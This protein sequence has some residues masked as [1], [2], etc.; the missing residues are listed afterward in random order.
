MSQGQEQLSACCCCPTFDCLSGDQ[1]GSGCCHGCDTLLLWCDRPRDEVKYLATATSPVSGTCIKCVVTSW[2][3]LPPVQAIYHYH[4]TYWRVATLGNGNGINTLLPPYPQCPTYLSTC[5]VPGYED[6]DNCNLFDQSGCACYSGAWTRYQID[7]WS[8]DNDSLWGPEIICFKGG[9]SIGPNHG[10]LEG[11]LLGLVYR[12]RWWKIAEGTVD[13]E[14]YRIYV[15][16]CVET[17]NGWQCQ[18]GTPIQGDNLVPKWWIYAC[19]G[20]PIFDFDIADAEERG[21]ITTQDAIDIRLALGQG[22][23]PAQDL[24]ERMAAGGYFDSKDWREDQRQAFIDLDAEFPGAGY[25]ACVED[26]SLMSELGPFRRRLCSPFSE[27]NPTPI[28]N[29][30][31]VKDTAVPLQ[32]DAGCFKDYPGSFSSGN[33]LKYQAWVDRQWVYLRAAPGGWTYA[34]WN[35]AAEC[36][37]P[38]EGEIAAILGGCGRNDPTC[39]A[40]LRGLPLGTAHCAPCVNPCD[41]ILNPQPVQYCNCECEICPGEQWSGF[42]STQCPESSQPFG[43]DGLCNG[44]DTGLGGQFCDQL[45]VEPFCEG[46]RFVFAHYKHEPDGALVGDYCVDKSRYTCRRTVRSYLVEARRSSDSWLDSVPYK[47]R[48]ESP[49]LPVFKDFPAVQQTHQV[50]SPIVVGLVDPAVDADPPYTTGDFCCGGFSPRLLLPDPTDETCCGRDPQKDCDATEECPPHS[51]SQ[52]VN[53]IGHPI[54]C[55]ET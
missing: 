47:C 34:G 50:I 45:G 9:N 55:T 51:L 22:D 21:F 37:Q 19:S 28:L 31:D 53:C 32:V 44:A 36:N 24:L 26:V 11:Q 18:D 52:Q 54:D 16:E 49:P 33:E 14:Q 20:C 15:P 17:P 1:I 25:G 27:A 13:C 39:I 41:S 12:E 2:D 8:S 5:F 38:E 29:R 4:G 43:F 6:C 40:A 30:A 3:S 10:R 23:Q 48:G 7:K 42:L 46:V 35:A